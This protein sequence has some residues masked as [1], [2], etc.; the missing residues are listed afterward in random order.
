M[1]I[2]FK[3]QLG[4]NLTTK[5]LRAMMEADPDYARLVPI[6][7]TVLEQVSK[8]CSGGTQ[9]SYNCRITHDRSIT[10]VAT[11]FQEIELTDDL[12]PVLP[13]KKAAYDN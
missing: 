13:E 8:T 4:Q 7:I 2:N 1:E 5:A 12:S 9:L 10:V 6:V 3:F 11:P